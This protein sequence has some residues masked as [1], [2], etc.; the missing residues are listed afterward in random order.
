M[1]WLARARSEIGTEGRQGTADTAERNATAVTAVPS[2]SVSTRSAAE[3]HVEYEERA[4]ILEF[5]GGMSRDDADR[6][7]RSLVYG[8][9]RLH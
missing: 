7:A 8:N 1:N 6:L 4:A 5:D 9:A 3:L 2:E